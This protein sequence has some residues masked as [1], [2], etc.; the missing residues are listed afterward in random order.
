MKI[1]YFTNEIPKKNFFVN[2]ISKSIF[3]SH[4]RASLYIAVK[5]EN[6]ELVKILLG[7]PGI[8][9]NQ[10]NIMSQFFKYNYKISF[11]N[12]IYKKKKF[13][14]FQLNFLNEIFLFIF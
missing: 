12:D 10:R 6:I 11:F 4:Q 3:F 14:M 7:Q 1:L 2:A 8:N 13:I 9:V 5:K